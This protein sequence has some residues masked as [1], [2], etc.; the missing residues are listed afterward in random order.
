MTRKSMPSAGDPGR[1]GSAPINNNIR[2]GLAMLWQA[3]AYA[4]EAGADIWDFAL[5]IDRLYASGVTISDLR[6]LV[7]KG[8]VEHGLES[9]VYGGP[10]RSFR[11]GT[12]FFF[13]HG[14]CVVLT[15]QGAAV[16][17]DFWSESIV[18][19]RPTR[20]EDTVHIAGGVNEAGAIKPAAVAKLDGTR[21]FLYKPLWVSTRR[22]L[23]LD[24]TIVKRFR[25]PAQNQELIL[26]AFEEDG[27]PEQIDDPLP[28]S[29]GIDPRT[30]LHDTVNRLN[31][32]QT[33]DLLRFHGNGNGTGVCWRLYR[34]VVLHQTHQLASRE[35]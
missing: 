17:G 23:S 12:G 14:T 18:P 15:P 7:A 8:F 24:G 21:C 9:S 4:Q 22:E 3:Y 30:R 2:I 33:N 11:P 31:R 25:V 1:S 29:G 26:S 20:A 27:W 19:P 34:P 16:A 28:I 10:H 13:E 35:E 32:R 5:E 6:W